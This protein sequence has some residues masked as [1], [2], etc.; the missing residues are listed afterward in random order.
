MGRYDF[1]LDLSTVNTM[2][3][4]NG[5]IQPGSRVLEFGPADGRLTSYLSQEKNCDVTI[6]ELDAESG[7]K[8]A[9]YAKNSYV[10]SL[11]LIH[12]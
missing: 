12:I 6:V 7:A 10:G 9:K 8:A 1:E 11:S 4:I 2:S 3:I 5:W